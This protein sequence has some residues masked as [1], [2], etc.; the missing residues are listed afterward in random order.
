MIYNDFIV[1]NAAKHLD[2][3]KVQ[4]YATLMQTDSGVCAALEARAVRKAED[5]WVPSHE[6]ITETC[7]RFKKTKEDM[8]VANSAAAAKQADERAKALAAKPGSQA[9]KEAAK[10]AEA[11]K[12]RELMGAEKESKPQPLKKGTG[13]NASG[14]PSN[15]GPR[16]PSPAR[17]KHGGNGSA[18][19]AAPPLSSAAGGMQ[20]P[21]EVDAAADALAQLDIS[22]PASQKGKTISSD[23]GKGG[24]PPRAPSP[25]RGGSKLPNTYKPP[26]IVRPDSRTQVATA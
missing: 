8:Q 13:A 1:T 6:W 18:G 24:A 23:H 9:S 21:S 17:K 25:K 10:A 11:A 12:A 4:R 20:P 26:T 22:D 5:A 2:Y 15:R 7:L 16:P 19:K 3:D 14:M